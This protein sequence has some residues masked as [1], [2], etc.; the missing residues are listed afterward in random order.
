MD[1]AFRVLFQVDEQVVGAA[2]R[3]AQVVV[4]RAVVEQQ[5]QRVVLPVHLFGHELHVVQRGVHFGKRAL[6]VELVQVVGQ[7]DDV[8]SNLVH[9][10]RQLRHVVAQQCVELPAA[11]AQVGRDFIGVAHDGRQV[12]VGRQGVERGD[13]RVHLAHDLFHLREHGLRLV[14]QPVRVGALERVARRVALLCLRGQGQMQ[15]ASSQHGGHQFGVGAFGEAHVVVHADFHYHMSGVLVIVLNV[16]YHADSVSV[17]EY[18][19]GLGQSLD[20]REFYIIG[21]AG[22]EQVD[23]FQEIQHDKK[24]GDGND[25]GQ[26]DF[27]FFGKV[28]IGD[29][30]IGTNA[31]IMPGVTL[32]DNVL[33]AAGS[34][35]TKSVPSGMVVAGNP[36]RCIGTVEQFIERNIKYNLESKNLSFKEKREFLL[37]LPADKFIQK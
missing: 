11:G 32:G 37:S 33:V 27:D 8:V 7:R 20:V 36:A 34:I 25:A 18:R 22:L 4:E 26:S 28:T 35:V 13:E 12:G 31:L 2:G 5:S 16:V 17:G 21:V 15:V 6:Q 24:N 1:V 30:Y 14:H 10:A 3:V 29:F 19:P 9:L 23:A